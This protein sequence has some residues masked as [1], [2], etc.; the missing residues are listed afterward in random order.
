LDIKLNARVRDRVT[1]TRGR[2]VTYVKTT[3]GTVYV[4]IKHDHPE[5]PDPVWIELE[6]LEFAR[7]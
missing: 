7:P 5:W 2:T 3:L 6:R 4:C 1:D